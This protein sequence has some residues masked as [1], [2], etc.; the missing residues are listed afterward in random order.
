MIIRAQVLTP[1]TGNGALA[2]AYRPQ[3]SDDYSGLTWKDATDTE[4][5]KLIPPVNLYIVEI[6]T[7]E[8]TY[9]AIA[10]DARYSIVW[11]EAAGQPIDGG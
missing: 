11:A 1:W 10:A 8:P 6:V 5:A 2:S 7:D 3:L 9:N 4:A